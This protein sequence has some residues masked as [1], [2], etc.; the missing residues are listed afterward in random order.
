MAP[1]ERPASRTPL[2]GR[3]RELLVDPNRLGA[4]DEREPATPRLDRRSGR[5][6]KSRLALEVS[7]ETEERGGRG[8]LGPESPVRGADAGGRR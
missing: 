8:V 5:I 1:A 3:D 6:G 4:R 2:V 7:A